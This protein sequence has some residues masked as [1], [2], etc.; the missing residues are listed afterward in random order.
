MQYVRIKSIDKVTHDTLRIVTEKPEGLT[1]KP[2]Q[3]TSIAIDR[4]GWEEENRPFTFSSLPED[5]NLEFII[6]TYP[7][8]D[9]TT[10]KLLDVEPGERLILNGIFGAIEYKGEGLFIA[11]GSGITPFLSILRDLKKRGEIGGSSLI[12]ANKTEKDIILK[13]ELE[14]MLGDNFVNVLSEEKNDRYEH[15]FITRE[16][17]EKVV[18]GSGSGKSGAAGSG[19]GRDDIN[20]GYYYLC[21][22]PPMMKALE[23]ILA[24]M[25]VDSRKIVKESF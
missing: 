18:A 19:D 22:P 3:A 10:D 13:N 21:G 24:A 15:G 4:K 14:D 12:F 7:D 17:V 1:F 16:L 25:K 2:G 11:G 20:S 5:D 8:H 9:G 23:E 6:K